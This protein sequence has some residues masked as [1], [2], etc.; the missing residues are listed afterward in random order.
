MR[1]AFL[2]R[3][4]PR[5]DFG[6]EVRTR[7]TALRVE[8]NGLFERVQIFLRAAEL[9]RPADAECQRSSGMCVRSA[10]K[11]CVRAKHIHP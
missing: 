10:G 1:R 6:V 5:P 3:E 11:R 2:R 9:E 8:I 7:A 4:V